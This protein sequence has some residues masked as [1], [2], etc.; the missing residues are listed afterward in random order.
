ML[1]ISTILG[2]RSALISGATGHS[3]SALDILCYLRVGV[4]F[5]CLESPVVFSSAEEKITP[6]KNAAQ[7]TMNIRPKISIEV[8]RLSLRH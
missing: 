2:V 1:S 4:S 5:F 7:T 6:K 3:G 8:S